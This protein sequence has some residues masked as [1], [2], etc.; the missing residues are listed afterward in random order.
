M[1][2]LLALILWMLAI[3]A[4]LGGLVWWGLG[5]GVLAFGT[6]IAAVNRTDDMEQ[7]FG[8]C[9]F[10]LVAMSIIRGVCALLP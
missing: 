8:L 6:S 9:L 4:L 3:P 1:R 10:A 2:S 7:F 5:F